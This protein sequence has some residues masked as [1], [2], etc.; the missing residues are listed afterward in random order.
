[1]FLLGFIYKKLDALELATAFSNWF[2][3]AS[4]FFTIPLTT[5]VLSPYSTRSSSRAF[6]W[7]SILVPLTHAYLLVPSY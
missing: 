6:P 4:T 2:S 7:S 1:M 3:P 5:I